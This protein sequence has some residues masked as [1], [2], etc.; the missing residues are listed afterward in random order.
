MESIDS[1]A[2]SCLLLYLPIYQMHSFST[3][4]HSVTVEDTS[5]L[6]ATA[7]RDC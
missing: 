1:E 5:M 4:I 7:L 3:E 6:E 2:S